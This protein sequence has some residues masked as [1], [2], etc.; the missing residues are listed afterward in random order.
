MNDGKKL[1][2][3]QFERIEAYLRQ[4]MSE[5]ERLQFEKE[6]AGNDA[7][8]KEVEIER[9]LM[10]AVEAG[11][12]KSRMEKIHRRLFQTPNKTMWIAIAASIILLVAVGIWLISRPDPVDRLYAESFTVDP[13]LPVPMSA[14]DDY[15]FYDAMVDYKKG[16]YDLAESKWSTLLIESPVNDTL[17]YYIG[18]CNVNDGNHDKAIPYL[19][20]VIQLGSIAFRG[21]SE[22][23]LAL[24]YLR[25]ED[26]EGLDKLAKESESDYSKRIRQL[27]K[28]LE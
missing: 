19:Q 3:A 24:C 12:M 13:G 28:D 4:T 27:I 8:R 9:E 6:M 23:Y 22:W 5:G 20:K 11:A 1:T 15:L 18:M 10:L 14:T 7:F 26:F 25:L 2:Q 21:K 16:K 17:L